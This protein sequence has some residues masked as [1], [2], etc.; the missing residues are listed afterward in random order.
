MKYICIKRASRYSPNSTS[1]DAAIL[2]AVADRLAAQGHGVLFLEETEAADGLPLHRDAAGIFTMSRSAEAL[3][4]EA[5]A[6]NLGIK[7]WNSALGR[8]VLTR[9]RAMLEAGCLGIALPVRVSLKSLPAAAPLPFPF[10]LKRDDGAAESIEDVRLVRNAEDWQA[11]LATAWSMRP[12]KA[13]CWHCEAHIEGD[14]LKFYGV[15][16][17]GFI[18]SGYPTADGFSFSK[19][20]LELEN[21][22]PHN[23]PYDAA[24]FKQQMDALAERLGIPVYGGDAI[25]TPDG[26][27]HLIDFNDWPSFSVCLEPAA[28]AIASLAL[29]DNRYRI[30]IPSGFILN[31]S[32]NSLISLISLMSAT[33]E[34]TFK[35]GDTEEWLDIHFTRPIGLLWARFFNHFDIHPNVVTVISIFLGAAAGVMFYYPDMTHTLIGILLLMW[36]N[37]YDSTDGQMARMTG[38]KTRLGRILDGFAGDV[39]FFSIYFFI[40]L[41][42]TPQWGWTIW[43]MAALAGLVCHAKQCQLADYY[44]NIH[45]FFLKGKSGSE[46]DNSTKVREDFKAASW[47]GNPVWKVFLYF[48]GNYTGSQEGMTPRFQAFRRALSVHF[49][50]NI[51]QSLRDDFR[52]GSL[53]LM[54]YAN[55][56]TF[57]TRAIMLYVSLLI[58]E[59]WLYFVGELTV[60]NI[61]WFYMRYKHEKLCGE[62]TSKI[63]TYA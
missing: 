25:V 22:K 38:K 50:D 4:A 3:A 5:E 62:L 13:I 32:L 37:F 41:R 49:G 61:L 47:K 46:L 1:R 57:N 54:K 30:K 23:Y 28:E 8:T 52:K 39:W 20:G 18:N 36:A 19:F 44:R 42:L 17:T 21:G 58:G 59:P 51:P 26:S 60:F 16:G 34:S 48:Y 2:R 14:L 24:A 27:S 45:L 55:I 40:C 53:P 43:A 12:G 7:V 56:L 9:E 29:M 10:W 6:E 31:F 63:E 11:A 15:A 35:S 33:L